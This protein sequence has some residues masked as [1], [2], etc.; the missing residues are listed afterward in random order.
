MPIDL[1]S[2]L[3]ILFNPQPQGNHTKT[4]IS[5]A[6]NLTLT[7]FN[8]ISSPLKKKA[9]CVNQTLSQ[10]PTFWAKMMELSKGVMVNFIKLYPQEKK[11]NGRVLFSKDLLRTYLEESYL[12]KKVLARVVCTEILKGLVNGRRK[13]IS[14][15]N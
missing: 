8:L 10:D 12:N 6:I 14:Q 1:N 2:S 13:S 11:V 4:L 15:L 7:Q 9:K 3:A 5:S